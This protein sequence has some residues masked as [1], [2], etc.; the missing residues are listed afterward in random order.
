MQE[1]RGRVE[2]VMGVLRK[3]A[4]SAAPERTKCE[5]EKTRPV[6]PLR[7]REKV[8]GSKTHN[9]SMIRSPHL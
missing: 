8:E 7:S 9:F 1:R 3:Q 2:M 4:V 6:G 5:K